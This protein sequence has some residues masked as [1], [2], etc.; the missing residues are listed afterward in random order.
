MCCA[1]IA[2]SQ[3]AFSQLVVGGGCHIGLP[4]VFACARGQGIFI[5]VQTPLMFAHRAI[6][7][8]VLSKPS[9]LGRNVGIE[10]KFGCQIHNHCVGMFFGRCWAS[11]PFAEW[12]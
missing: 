7:V 8:D 11:L 4:C 9:V 2:V 3:G 1:E 10:R 12:R 6:A 5:S